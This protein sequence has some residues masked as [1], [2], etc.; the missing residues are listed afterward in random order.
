MM[1]I[2]KVWNRWWNK[3]WNRGNK[4]KDLYRLRVTNRSLCSISKLR[5]NQYI[6]Y[7]LEYRDLR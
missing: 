2:G 5:S 3:E 7:R 6:A 1:K 4:A